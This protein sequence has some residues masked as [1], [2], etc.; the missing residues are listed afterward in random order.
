MGFQAIHIPF[1]SAQ[2]LN[3]FIHSEEFSGLVRFY[4]L[5]GIALTGEIQRLG[6]SRIISFS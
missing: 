5:T 4:V 3:Q 6:A 2:R 1:A